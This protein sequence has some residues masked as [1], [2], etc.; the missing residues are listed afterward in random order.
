MDG[1]YRQSPIANCPRPCLALL[2]AA[3]AMVLLA[4][5]WTPKSLVT[6]GRAKK[7]SLVTTAGLS[8]AG[9][10]GLD[11][12]LSHA[13]GVSCRFHSSSPWS[14]PLVTGTGCGPRRGH[15]LLGSATPG[16][17]WAGLALGEKVGAID[18]LL[19]FFSPWV[20]C[21]LP[22]PLLLHPANDALWCR[23]LFPSQSAI[24]S[25]PIFR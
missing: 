8:T 3:L 21:K 22:C 25:S 5:G 12:R 1:R 19:L 11:G 17:G 7:V 9:V 20:L 23:R 6:T 10:D 18:T 15:A 4:F 16:F 13:E 2:H 14:C 24:A